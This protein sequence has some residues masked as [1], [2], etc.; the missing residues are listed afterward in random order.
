MERVPVTVH[1][2]RDSGLHGITSRDCGLLTGVDVLLPLVDA[3]ELTDA[4]STG[5]IKSSPKAR[6][7]S[8]AAAEE[9]VDS[10]CGATTTD[11]NVIDLSN[12]DEDSVEITWPEQTWPV[13]TSARD[14]DTNTESRSGVTPA[15]DTAATLDKLQEES[16]VVNEDAD[17]SG[18]IFEYTAGV[19]PLS[20]DAAGD[21]TALNSF[22]LEGDVL[23]AFGKKR[24]LCVLGLLEASRFIDINV[25]NPT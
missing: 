8:T 2:D 4:V 22:E 20:A 24:R 15:S 14:V 1:A 3:T 21:K 6:L 7:V 19:L 12:S 25:F 13:S 16:T 9:P 11:G 5:E 18:F 17:F 23:Q 10:T